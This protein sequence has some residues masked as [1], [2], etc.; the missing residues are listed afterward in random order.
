MKLNNYVT[1]GI[2]FEGI[3]GKLATRENYASEEIKCTLF[4]LFQVTMSI[5]IVYIPQ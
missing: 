5:A 3:M 4:L 2:I 1:T